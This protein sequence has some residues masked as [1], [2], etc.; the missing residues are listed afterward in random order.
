MYRIIRS[1]YFTNWKNSQSSQN[2]YCYC[3]HVIKILL[4]YLYTI[5]LHIFTEKKLLLSPHAPVGTQP[6]DQEGA[7]FVI[8]FMF[9]YCLQ[10][11]PILLGLDFIKSHDKQRR[12]PKCRII[13]LMRLI[14]LM[15]RRCSFSQYKRT[16]AEHS[17]RIHQN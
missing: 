14:L 5:I 9:F 2:H 13:F 17:N 4:S 3:Q 15:E 7:R 12:G 8:F 16:W 6:R 11:P 1:D 10:H